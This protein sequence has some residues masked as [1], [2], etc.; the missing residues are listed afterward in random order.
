MKKRIDRYKRSQWLESI[1]VGVL[2]LECFGMLYKAYYMVKKVSLVKEGFRQ[3]N[4]GNWIEA[5]EKLGQC[6]KLEYYEYKQKKVEDR[7]ET[8]KWI[9]EN[10]GKVSHIYENLLESKKNV[11]YQL[12][13]GSL[14]EYETLDIEKLEPYQID[15]FKEVYPIDEAT[16]DAW[17]QFKG[18]M[19]YTLQN[20]KDEYLWAKE[21]ILDVPD[22][23]F[24][25][26]KKEAIAKLFEA[27]DMKLFKKISAN[28]TELLKQMSEF[29]KIYAVNEKYGYESEWLTE[30]IKQYIRN[31][32]SGLAVAASSEG[33]DLIKNS[34]KT[35]VRLLATGES[36]GSSDIDRFFYDTKT[37]IKNFSNMIRDYSTCQS[38]AY[39]DEGIDQIV[40]GYIQQ[41]QE[42]IQVLLN[43]QYY[44][45]AI[46]WYRSMEN[47]RS[48]SREIQEIDQIKYFND[49][50]LLIEK[51]MQD[52]IYYQVGENALDTNKYLIAINKKL[53]QLEIYRMDTEVSEA[54]ETKLTI[55]M[56]NSYLDRV[57]T[58]QVNEGQTSNENGGLVEANSLQ[59]S[60]NG[61]LIM[62]L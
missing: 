28:N 4:E 32:I 15:Y 8:L 41:K 31:K 17:I 56:E 5:E 30:P 61:E 43:A 13:Q 48:F 26:G 46:E 29:D 18:D 59:V 54:H 38:K 35:T 23:Y 9:T 51:N 45:E 11:D 55:S 44:D 14:S 27:C 12:F 60:V 49:P 58:S 36:G 6:V 22:S 53:K 3:F 34:P 52:Y 16:H 19:Q 62:I 1:V 20:A 21:H 25:S 24:S 7:L 50:V 47:L 57:L 10:N 37:Q 2:V 40:E 33:L 39:Y 42:E